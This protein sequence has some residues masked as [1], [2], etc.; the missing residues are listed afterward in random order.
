MKAL[1]AT[2]EKKY[3]IK[4]TDKFCAD[5]V[6]I[7]SAGEL[8]RKQGA[9]DLGV[10]LSTLNKRVMSHCDTDVVSDDDLDLTCK[11][12]RLQRENRILE[13]EKEIS[14]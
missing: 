3:E 12:E 4:R 5:A 8:A 13:E 7:A 10:G 1:N 14:K 11:N 6:Q 2:K 9:L